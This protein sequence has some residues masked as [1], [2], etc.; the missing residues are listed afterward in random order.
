MCK[1]HGYVYHAR[2]EGKVRRKRLMKV[3]TC[4]LAGAMLAGSVGFALAQTPPAG[5][6]R[7]AAMR[8]AC[9]DDIGKLCADKTGRD[10]RSCLTDNK[11]KVSATCK[12]AM[13]APRPGQ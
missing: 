13:D 2:R 7:G 3:A 12:A 1:T 10:I 9:G 4:L 8:A 6:G 5:G 11:D